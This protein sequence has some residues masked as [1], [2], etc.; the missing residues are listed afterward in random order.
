MRKHTQLFQH[1]P[2]V[3]LTCT[4]ILVCSITKRPFLTVLVATN[5][6]FGHLQYQTRVLFRVSYQAAVSS[7]VFNVHLK[8]Y[9]GPPLRALQN[10]SSD[11]RVS[12][13]VGP[14]IKAEGWFRPTTA[15]LFRGWRHPVKVSCPKVRSSLPSLNHSGIANQ[16]QSA[17]PCLLSCEALL[18]EQGCTL[19]FLL[20][21]KL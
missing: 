8:F 9:G 17:T 4:L 2:Q 10:I 12:Q 1:A 16:N 15:P 3:K 18:A 6:S 7:L 14:L 20:L 21:H 11:P 13:K 19:D 5:Q